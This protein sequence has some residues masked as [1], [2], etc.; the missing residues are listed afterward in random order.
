MKNILVSVCIPVYN[1]EAYL[2]ETLNSVTKQTYKNIEIIISDNGSTD[3]T[4]EIVESYVEKDS[5][6]RFTSNTKFENTYSGNCNN[7]INEAKGKYV[8]IYH[9]DDIYDA[10]IVEKQLQ[11]LEN[12]S[13][14]AGVFTFSDLIN[15]HS[16]IIYRK[17]FKFEKIYKKK[18]I[19]EVNMDQY[20]H[21]FIIENECLLWCPTSMIKKSVYLEL[22]GYKNI[23]YIEDQDMWTRIL[24]KY[25]LIVINERLIKYRLHY[26][27]GSNYYR[28]LNRKNLAPGLIYL[29]KY[30]EKN[31]NYKKKYES[32]LSKL[33][34][35]DYI[36]L[37]MTGVKLKS[38]IKYKENISKSKKTFKFSL[39]DKKYWIIQKFVG[40]L[41]FKLAY[42]I[43]KLIWKQ[44]IIE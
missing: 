12:H 35:K 7:L 19:V 4:K 29:K 39:N 31:Y 13:K 15:T 6:I 16:K 9:A 32:Q 40:K 24:N 25:K 20:L 37:A 43:F 18:K 34:A 2:K 8:A 17:P 23:K 14:I 30:F 11:I 5:I 33:I 26:K 38:Y 3:K 41:F 36:Y 27:Q 1:G 21:F 44:K 10:N 22:G 28:S 42:Y